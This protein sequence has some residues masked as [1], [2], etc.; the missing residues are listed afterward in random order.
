MQR[1]KQLRH[2]IYNKV[3]MFVVVDI[4]RNSIRNHHLKPIN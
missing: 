4:F 2:T 3:K 1:Y